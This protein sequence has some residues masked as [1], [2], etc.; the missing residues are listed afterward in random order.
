MGT[1]PRFILLTRKLAQIDQ[2]FFSKLLFRP[3]R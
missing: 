2:L 3:I 1:F